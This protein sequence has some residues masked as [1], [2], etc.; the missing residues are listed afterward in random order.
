VTELNSSF[1]RFDWRLVDVE[2][3]VDYIDDQG[4]V[5]G[6]LGIA[7]EHRNKPRRFVSG[8]PRRLLGKTVD[9]DHHLALAWAKDLENLAT[10]AEAKTSEEDRNLTLGEKAL[11]LVLPLSAYD[12]IERYE[13]YDLGHIK[14]SLLVRKHHTRTRRIVLSLID[15]GPSYHFIHAS[16]ARRIAEFITLNAPTLG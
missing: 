9:V 5:F 14:E 13:A 4:V 16:T 7:P 8:L 10:I 12:I 6:A 3:W 11:R 2:V 1:A 15:E